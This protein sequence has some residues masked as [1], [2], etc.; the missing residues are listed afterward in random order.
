MIRDSYYTKRAKII[1]VLTYIYNRII[2]PLEVKEGKITIFFA[3]LLWFINRLF[4][5]KLDLPQLLKRKYVVTKFGKYYLEPDLMSNIIVSPAFERSDVNYLIN[6]V[7]QKI[8]SKKRVLFVDVGAYLGTYTITLSTYFKQNPLLHFIL[9]EP[10]ANVFPKSYHLLKK[11]LKTNNVK[12]YKLF[13]FG[14]GKI[15]AKKPNFFGVIVKKFDSVINKKFLNGFDVLFLKIDIEGFESEAAEGALKSIA[16][17][18][19]IYCLV[20]DW[21]NKDINRFLKK[22]HFVCIGKRSDYNIFWHRINK[23]VSNYSL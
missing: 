5:T 6:L 13:H 12:N 11:N 3:D 19:E 17:F 14:L 23:N 15:N 18:P 4:R 2:S 9:F 1:F 21:G 20:E 8:N 7:R 16:L 22:H 10:E